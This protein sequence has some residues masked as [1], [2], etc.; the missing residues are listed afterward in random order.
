MT[1]SELSVPSERDFFT[2][3]SVTTNSARMFLF[4][5]LSN[6]L[7]KMIKALFEICAAQWASSFFLVK[8]HLLGRNT[9]VVLSHIFKWMK[10]LLRFH[11]KCFHINI[12]WSRKFLIYICY[13]IDFLQAVSNE[14]LSKH[15]KMHWSLLENC[16][17]CFVLIINLKWF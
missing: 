3:K 15:N 12:I 17:S 2:I 6:Y 8:L 10:S 11:C 14:Y 13:E 9:L 1:E 4:L 5:S 7:Y 16:F